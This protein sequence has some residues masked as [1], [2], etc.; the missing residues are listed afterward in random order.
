M[1]L[2]SLSAKVLGFLLCGLF[3]NMRWMCCYVYIDNYLQFLKLD[4]EGQFEA[5]GTLR[6]EALNTGIYRH[7]HYDEQMNLLYI[8]RYSNEIE[9]LVMESMDVYRWEDT[10]MQVMSHLTVE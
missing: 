5:M 10:G 1:K 7:Y 4:E 2:I 8:T 3:G 6:L 9:D